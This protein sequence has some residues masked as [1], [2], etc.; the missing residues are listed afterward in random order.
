MD[1][2][3]ADQG[4]G[5]G[6]MDDAFNY[7]IAN[8]GLDGEDTYQY[9]GIDEACW[10]DG[11]AR[12]VASFRSFH[13]VPQNSSAQLEAAVRKQPVSVGI[14]AGGGFMSYKGGVLDDS[15]GCDGEVNHGVLVVGFTADYWIVKNSWGESWGESGY[16]RMARNSTKPGGICNILTQAS[17]PEAKSGAPMPLPPAPPTPQPPMPGVG[18]GCNISQAMLCGMLGQ[19]S[20]CCSGDNVHCSEPLPAGQCC[21][22]G[23]EA[24]CKDDRDSSSEQFLLEFWGDALVAGGRASRRGFLAAPRRTAAGL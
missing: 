12:A 10:K 9:Y 17:Y 23:P 15:A 16:V 24:Q 7:T 19:V 22:G 2:V 5:G 21:A 3:S 6:L 18:C 8:S 4:C 1:C 14:D 20:C 13:D 11:E